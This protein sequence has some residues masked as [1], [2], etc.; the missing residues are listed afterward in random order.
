MILF[1]VLRFAP[2]PSTTGNKELNKSQNLS[3]YRHKTAATLE[4]EKCTKTL[5]VRR[6]RLNICVERG[7]MGGARQHKGHVRRLLSLLYISGVDG[8]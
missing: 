3:I 8:P 6:R 4:R 5:L 2:F 7:K 1:V